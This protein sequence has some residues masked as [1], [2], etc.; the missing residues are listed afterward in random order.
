MIL[1][2]KNLPQINYIQILKKCVV[3]SIYQTTKT[4]YSYQ[5]CTGIPLDDPH[6]DPYVDRQL[7]F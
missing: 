3:L 2:N 5:Y 6:V 1:L 4:F 7:F